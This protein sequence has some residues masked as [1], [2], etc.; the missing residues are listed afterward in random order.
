MTTLIIGGSGLTGQALAQLLDTAGYPVLLTSRSGKVPGTFTGI[1]FDWYDNTTFENP[2]KARTSITSVFIKGPLVEESLAVAQPFIDLAISKGVKKFVLL[3]GVSFD[4]GMP[5]HGQLHQYLIDSGVNYTVLRA[6]F[7]MENFDRF[8]GKFIKDDNA[9]FSVAEDGKIPFVHTSDIARAAFE[10]LTTDKYAHQDP[11]LI[12]PEL[13]TQDEVAEIFTNALGRRIEHKRVTIEEHARIFTS[14][15]WPP[16][17]VA[18]R[19]AIEMT[20]ASGEVEKVFHVA[21]EKKFV[22]RV[23]LKCYIR[24]NTVVWQ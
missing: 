20:V 21:S 13:L 9:I 4:P 5:F 6:S 1:P 18:R 24:E 17:H 10:A 15:G 22:G 3:S 7:F 11:Y 19:G 2:F 12:G 16:A 8:T 14:L 23:T